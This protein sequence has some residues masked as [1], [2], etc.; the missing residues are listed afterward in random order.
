MG[1]YQN[2]EAPRRTRS[3]ARKGSEG[4]GA[5][6]REG[7][8]ELCCSLSPDDFRFTKARN[9]RKSSKRQK[10]EKSTRRRSTQYLG[11]H[12]QEGSCLLRCTVLSCC[13]NDWGR[14]ID[15]SKGTR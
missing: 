10:T 8:E 14:K 1:E 6:H 2:R 4:F 9:R 3:K 13:F 12:G 5:L 15:P 11:P 7:A